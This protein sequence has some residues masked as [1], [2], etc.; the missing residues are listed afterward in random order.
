MMSDS[1]VKEAFLLQSQQLKVPDF[2]FAIAN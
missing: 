1:E 2:I